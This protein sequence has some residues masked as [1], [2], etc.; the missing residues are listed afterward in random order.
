M[1]DAAGSQ[2]HFVCVGTPQKR[3]AYVVSIDPI[4][5]R[6]AGRNVF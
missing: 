6:T 2:V 5:T 1:A 4:K 3:G